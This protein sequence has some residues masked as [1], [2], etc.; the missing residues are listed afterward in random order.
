MNQQIIRKFKIFFGIGLSGILI[1]FAII[2]MAG[3]TGVKQVVSLGNDPQLKEKVRHITGEINNIPSLAK[4]GCWDK[5][6]G[7]LNVEVWI[8]KPIA[9]NLNSL[10]LACFT[11]E[12]SGQK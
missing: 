7:F 2:V 4:V 8:E 12:S 11:N 3:V 5:V 6:Q 1:L 10:K 9:D